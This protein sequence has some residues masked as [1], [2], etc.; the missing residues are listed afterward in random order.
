MSSN[1]VRLSERMFA[2]LFVYTRV[3][4]QCVPNVLLCSVFGHF[5]FRPPDQPVRIVNHGRISRYSGIIL[6]SSATPL[7]PCGFKENCVTLL[8]IHHSVTIHSLQSPTLL[9]TSSRLLLDVL[10]SHDT[11][12]APLLATFFRLLDVL[13][14][15]TTCP[16]P[17]ERC[18]FRPV[19]LGAIGG[20][21]PAR[22]STRTF[23]WAKQTS[24]D[25]L[26]Y[27]TKHFTT[28]LRVYKCVHRAYI[29]RSK[30]G[31]KAGGKHVDRP[32]LCI[33]KTECVEL[34]SI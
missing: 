22:Q 26:V 10:F 28:L 16:L 29:T 21:N 18:A 2:T 31:R 13:F 20:S 3:L 19:Q 33:Y 15:A 5:D 8:G 23:L 25:I 9:A 7:H 27:K 32:R 12:K 24:K 1:Y 6:Q 11:Y 17:P 34:N 4:S 14:S 30:N